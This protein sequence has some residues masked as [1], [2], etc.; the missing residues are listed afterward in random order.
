MP[1]TLSVGILGGRTAS[2][3]TSLPSLQAGPRSEGLTGEASRA[4]ITSGIRTAN[5][6]AS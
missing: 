6:A 1:E 3:D 2:G 4:S 5:G